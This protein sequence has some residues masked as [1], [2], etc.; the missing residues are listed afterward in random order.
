MR[1][2]KEKLRKQKKKYVKGGKT[3][4]T[5]EKNDDETNKRYGTIRGGER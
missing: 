2:R 5:S 1:R 3:I 4:K